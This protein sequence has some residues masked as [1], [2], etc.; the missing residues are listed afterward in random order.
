M[1][2]GLIDVSE[3]ARRLGVRTHRIYDLVRE[4]R[5]PGVVRIGRQVR[6]DPAAL[7]EWIANG[8]DNA[9]TDPPQPNG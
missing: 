5:M 1:K 7:D 2:E 4:D 3:A 8:G 9:Y 6:I